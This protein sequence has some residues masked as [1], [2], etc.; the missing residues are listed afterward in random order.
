MTVFQP[1]LKTSR[2]ASPRRIATNLLITLLFGLLAIQALPFGRN[3][4]NPPV[5]AEPAWDSATTRV[6]FMRACADCHSNETAWPW[7][8]SVAPV[9]WL[10]ARDVVEGRQKLNISEWGR[11]EQEADDAAE[12]VQKG[13]MPL[14]FYIPLHPEAALMP[15]EREQL[16]AG[17]TATFGGEHDDRSR[18][19][20]S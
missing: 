15:I 1:H 16:I 18:D 9:S 5:L 11:A 8:S 13:E 6:L 4:T 3:H 20:D 17:L 2:R 12:T 19:A 14:W 10:V 7:Y